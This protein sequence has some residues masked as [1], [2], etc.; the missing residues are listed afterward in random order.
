MKVTKK[1]LLIM[2]FT[3][4]MLILLS[5]I[6]GYSDKNYKPKYGITTANVNFRKTA[7]LDKSNII[8]I[9]KK[10]SKIKLVGE[11][12]NFY[13]VQL[14]NNQVG[15]IS[16]S[17]VKISGSSL[18]GAYV[19]EN[20]AKY[21]ATVNGSNTNVRG[22]PSTNFKSYTKLQKGNIVQVIGKINNF[23][24][25]ITQNNTVGM[26]RSDLITKTSLTQSNNTS[27]NSSNTNLNINNTN[28]TTILNLINN[29][30]VKNNLSKLTLNTALT[31]VA[32]IKADDMVKN[33]YFSHTSPNYGSP[34]TMMQS[35]G[36]S[37]KSA[38]ENIAGNSNI[39]NAVNSWL[40]SSTHK[41]NLL[42]K[43]FNNLGIGISKS[44]T[45]GYVIVVMLIQT[46]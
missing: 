31:N 14:T 15:L 28:I 29:A 33:N 27:N 37:Y 13:I 3:M 45:Y 23:N 11:V 12:S 38:G 42:S 30:R 2:Y 25:I 7:T 19:Y 17:Y 1:Q 6:F 10:N 36:I 16:K 8:Q 35:L 43:S 44:N 18:Q 46:K 4:L 9:V 34:F 21:F 22:G 24:M 41:K 40:N 39:T 5:N 20:Y 32:Q 26:I